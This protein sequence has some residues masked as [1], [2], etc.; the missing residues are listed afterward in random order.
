MDFLNKRTY[1]KLYNDHE[2]YNKIKK[3][4]INE[5]QK[6]SFIEG[7][8]F[9]INKN[10]FNKYL[11]NDSVKYFGYSVSL[12]NNDTLLISKMNTSLKIKNILESTKMQNNVVCLKFDLIE[13][14]MTIITFIKYIK[15]YNKKW[16]D[17]CISYEKKILKINID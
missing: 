4:F 14:Y 10:I 8:N 9:I 5:L 1:E 2:I 7:N 6:I 16:L 11:T 17:L 13:R 15:Q 12:Y 3:K